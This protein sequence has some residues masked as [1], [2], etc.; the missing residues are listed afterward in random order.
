MMAG[1]F[2]LLTFIS[3]PTLSLYAPLREA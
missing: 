2:Y 3:I 1:G